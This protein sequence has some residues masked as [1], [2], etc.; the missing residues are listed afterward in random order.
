MGAGLAGLACAHELER[1][2]IPCVIFERKNMT[3][4]IQNNIG[5]FFQI[6]DR[7]IKDPFNY[8]RCMYGI[9]L[10]PVRRMS[11]VIM[12]SPKYQ[13]TVRGNLGYFI[14]RSQD[15]NS[16]ENQLVRSVTSKINYNVNPD[17]RELAN[18]YDFVVVAT[19][20]SSII[21]QLSEWKTTIT[22]WVK[23]ATVLGDFDPYT[24]VLWFN[25][26]Y[27]RSGY[28]YLMPFDQHRATLALI[29]TYAQHGELDDLWNLFLHNE[30]LNY[31]IIETFE[32][33][34][35]TGIAKEHKVNNI[36][37]VGNAAGFIDPL[38]GLGAFHAIESGIFAARS[39][40]MGKDYEKMVKKI[41]K[42]VEILT[43]Y[44][45]FIDKLQ[46]KDYDR[47]IRLLGLPIIRN[48][49]YGSNI[50]VIKYAHP[51]I[52]ILK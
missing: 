40:A 15:V 21:E 42:K 1:L 16:L 48:V 49:I 10:E 14:L 25:T 36:Y 29:T 13:A 38:L 43:N 6:E 33:D 26:D 31:E 7:P 41:V 19:G 5:A 20:N 34:V 50:N 35:D 27:A 4:T 23:G 17:Y 47:F 51:I 37:F 46:N 30:G 39:I 9:S 32:L 22:T 52:R 28:G 44:R 11:T 45:T 8:L 12:H 18:D 24:A 2:G 3:G